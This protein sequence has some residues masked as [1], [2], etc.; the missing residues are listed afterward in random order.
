MFY[1]LFHGSFIACGHEMAGKKI[2]PDGDDVVF[3]AKSVACH[4]LC[5]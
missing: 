1:G 5:L 3:F 4:V 2:F